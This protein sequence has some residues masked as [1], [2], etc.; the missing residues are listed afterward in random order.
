[1]QLAL[2]CFFS[3]NINLQINKVFPF[4]LENQKQSFGYVLVYKNTFWIFYLQLI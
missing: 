3:A 1:M 4:I 2:K